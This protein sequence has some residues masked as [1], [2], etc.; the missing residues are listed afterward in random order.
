[1][2]RILLLAPLLLCGCAAAS[3]PPEDAAGAPRTVVREA[4][5]TLEVMLATEVNTASTALPATVERA[6]AELPGVYSQMGIE[7]RTSEPA[8]HTLGNINFHP[9]GGIQG[10]RVSE[11]L[12]CGAGNLGS[13]I[14]DL[15]SVRVNVRSQVVADGATSR[16]LTTLSAAARSTDGASGGEVRCV[17][18][19]KLESVI[20]AGML[21]A[22]SR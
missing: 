10:R 8:T 16:V 3:V 20:G 13:P 2:R 17:T 5:S 22:V 15:Y 14:A 7:V 11:F 18:R 12:D 21:L 6:W 4:G 19:G 9:R 1:M